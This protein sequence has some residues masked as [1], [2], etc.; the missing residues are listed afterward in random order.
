MKEKLAPIHFIQHNRIRIQENLEEF[1]IDLYSL[2]DLDQ[3]STELHGERSAAVPLQNQIDHDNIH[4][5][6][7]SHLIA[8]EKRMAIL[9]KEITEKKGEESLKN[10]Y[11]EFGQMLGA[12]LKENI[13]FHSGQELYGYISSIVL[14]GMPCDKINVLIESGD[15]H[16]TWHNVRDIHGK[17]FED[18]GLRGSYFYDL[19][20]SFLTGFLK[21]VGDL[22]FVMNRTS[23]AIENRVNF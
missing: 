9:V 15:H 13:Q 11:A 18:V 2:Q 20:E 23:E 10:A 3:E 14:D 21:S 7:E 1:L 19:R 5:W 22:S 8:N 6:L 17:Y 16:I 4:G 12:S